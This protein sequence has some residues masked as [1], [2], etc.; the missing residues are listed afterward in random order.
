[1]LDAKNP[2]YYDLKG[3]LVYD[4]CIGQF[5]Y[6]QEEVPAVPF[7]IENNNLFNFNAS[8]LAELESLHKSCGYEK[9]IEEYLQFPPKKAQPEVYF[10]FTS[11]ANCDVFDLINEAAFDPNP[12]FNIYEINQMCPLPWDVLSFPT[13]LVFTPEGAT[14][15]FNRSDVKAALH[16]PAN[17]NWAECSLVEVYVGGDAG[18]QGEGDTSADPIQKVLPQVIEA[19]NRVL[20]GNGDYDMIILTNGTLMSIQ[21]MTWGGKMG[22]QTKPTTPIN[23]Q[24]ADLQYQD[25]FAENGLEGY[26]GPQ[27]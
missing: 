5:D 9:Y 15:Y 1:M 13:E 14:T 4:P 6:T 22:F 27:G 18:P 24:L 26:D 23:I 25:V 21:N 20:V 7:V 10:N 3:A 2:T 17:S 12:C 11:E 19:T 16:A 8:F